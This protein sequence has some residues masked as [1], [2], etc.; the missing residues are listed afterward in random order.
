MWKGGTERREV[1]SIDERR[2]RNGTVND[3][4]QQVRNG[5]E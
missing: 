3:G 4:T 5:S 2:E 1:R